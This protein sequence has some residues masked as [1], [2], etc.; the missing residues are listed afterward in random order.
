MSE[1]LNSIRSRIESLGIGFQFV[2][3]I[4]TGTNGAERETWLLEYEGSQFIFVPGQKNVTLGWDTDKC[5]LGDGVLEGLQKEFS[6][7]HEYYY[8]EEL[9]GLKGDYQ[10]QID[11]AEENGDSGKA[12]ELR[13]ELAEELKSWNEDIEEKGYASWEG[14]LAKWNEHLSQCLSPLRTA[15]IRDMIVEVDSRYLDEDAPSLE[16]AVLSLKQGLFTLPTEDEWEYLCNG[17][18]RTL[19]RWGD[20]LSGVMTEIFNVGAV[21][22]TRENTI[23][24]QPNMLG[25]FIA[26]DSYKNEII[27]NTSFTKGGD[28]GCSLCGGDG[29]IYVLPCYTAFYRQPTNERH[30]ELSKNYFCYRRI[31]RLT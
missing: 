4:K 11:E 10:E 18:T 8:E 15:D 28:G 25:L 19:F 7:G 12:D 14:F 17:G 24:E 3:T 27:D 1:L 30:S 26:Y 31:I 22:E 13:S 5:L 29:A 2:K 16:Q 21:G 6:S 23:L 20:T 9:E